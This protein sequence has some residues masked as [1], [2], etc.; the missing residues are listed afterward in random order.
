M[1]S[2]KQIQTQLKSEKQPIRMQASQFCSV[3]HCFSADLDCVF[4]MQCQLS[5]LVVSLFLS[6]RVMLS[7]LPL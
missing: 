3:C 5:R 4:S 2:E 7:N 6:V 1:R